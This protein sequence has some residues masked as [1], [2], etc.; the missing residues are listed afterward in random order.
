MVVKAHCRRLKGRARLITIDLD[1]TGAPTH[2]QQEF[3]FFNGHY[4]SWCYLPV[5]ATLTFNEEPEQHLVT[6]VLRPGNSPAK[7]GA[8]GLLRRLVARVRAAFPGAPIRVRLDGGF[9]GPEMLECLEAEQVEYVVGLAS[10]VRLEKRARRLLGRRGCAPGPVGK[11]SG[12]TERPGMPPG[13][14]R[15]SGA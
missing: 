1:P 11:Q 15:T 3:T 10:N 4:D 9:A 6:A 13:R 7:L 2:G 14:G 5:V 8:I 12:C